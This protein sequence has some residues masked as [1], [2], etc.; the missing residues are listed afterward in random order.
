LTDP[1]RLSAL[2]DAELKYGTASTLTLPELFRR[3]SEATWKEA[4]KA[5][6]ADVPPLRRS[7]QRAWLDRMTVLLVKPPD[8]MPADARALARRELRDVHDRLAERLTAPVK[9]DAYT[10]AHFEDVKERIEKALAAE[11]PAEAR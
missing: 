5:P 2:R 1:Y 10:Q 9:L 11:Y 8:H 6:A 7:L 3:L 4:W